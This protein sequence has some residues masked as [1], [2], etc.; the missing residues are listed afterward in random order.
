M[1]PGKYPSDDMEDMAGFGIT[2][3]RTWWANAA[4][5]AGLFAGHNPK[6]LTCSVMAIVCNCIDSYALT[7]S[8]ILWWLQKIISSVTI[9]SDSTFACFHSPEQK[10]PFPKLASVLVRGHTSPAAHPKVGLN[11]DWSWMTRCWLEWSWI[12]SEFQSPKNPSQS[13][14]SQLILNCP[15]ILSMISDEYSL[16]TTALCNWPTTKECL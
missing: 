15:F 2:A 7:W 5:S 1:R 6:E 10:D 4:G 8:Y 11:N 14:V 3:H 12:H 9:M 13:V 16:S